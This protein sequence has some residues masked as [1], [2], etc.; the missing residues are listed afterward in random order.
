MKISEFRN[1]VRIG[2]E[3]NVRSGISPDGNTKEELKEIM[4]KRI[5]DLDDVKDWSDRVIICADIASFAFMIASK[6]D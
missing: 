4:A 2:Y 3:R 5:D 6:E 1:W